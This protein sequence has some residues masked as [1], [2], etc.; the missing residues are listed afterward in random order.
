MTSCTKIGSVLV[1]ALGIFGSPA[2]SQSTATL[3]GK[4]TDSNGN[5]VY[6]ANV[7]LEGSKSGTS[8]DKEGNY[9]LTIPAG[10]ECRI[11]FSFIGFQP[12]VFE[13]SANPGQIVVY[14]AVLQ[15]SF[16]TIDEV[17]VTNA[18]DKSSNLTRINTRSLEMLPNTN[19]GI[20]TILKTLPGVSSNNEL[21]SQYSVR[22][23]NFDENLVFV[24]GI[25]VYRPFLI[26]SGQQEGLSFINPDLVGS[27]Q[28]SA[29]GFDAGYGDKMSS[30]LDVTYK[31]PAIYGGSVS[32]SLLG[33]SAHLEGSDKKHRFTHI[34][35]IR[36]KTSQYLLGT[37]DTK[38]EY[39]PR[40][41]DFQTY[42]TY[43]VS[44]TF[45]LGFLGNISRNVY[46]FI[47]VNR[48]TSFGTVSTAYKLKIYFDGQEID[49]YTGY[50]GA[51]T[52]SLHPSS[53]M[54]LRFT[55]SFYHTGEQEYFD[56]Q[57]Q[58]LINE[59]DTRIGSQTFG[60]SIK[61]IGVGTFLDHAR[62]RLNMDIWTAEHSG[63]VSLDRTQVRWG[64][65]LKQE[66]IND[67]LNE[68]QM[69]DS[70]G[71]SLPYSDS[72]INLGSVVKT[73]N[74]LS[75][76][77]FAAYLLA[78]RQADL[79]KG[80]LYASGGIRV[81]YFDLNRQFFVNPRFSI[82]FDPDWKRN[83]QFRLAAGLYFQPPLYKEMRNPAGT[84]NPNLRAQESYQLLMGSDYI[85]SLWNRPFKLT[86]EVYY[87]Y[88]DKL[89][90]Y[91]VDNVRIVYLGENMARGY[92]TGMDFKIN[93]E[94]VE[95]TESWASLSFMKTM[96]D[97]R[98]DYYVDSNG[99]KVPIG[100]YP[101]P[102]DQRVNFGMFFQDYLP[103]N[104][105]YRVNLYFL[106]GSRLPFSPPF[107]AR[108]DETYRMPAYKRVDIG[109]S[110]VIK[111]EHTSPSGTFWKPFKTI[112]VTGEIFNLFGVNNTISYLWVRTVS[113]LQN[114]PGYF[115]VPNY[116]T[117][118]RLNLRLTL[119]F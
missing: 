111:D 47:P 19:G 88:L 113:N 66:R 79:A 70:A 34:S 92:A 43:H 61:N 112:L 89:V 84:V 114:M 76:V 109:F 60:D 62:N 48:E 110:K 102:T 56:L 98:G 38:G 50:F 90:P 117:S 65:K 5:A 74:I 16:K 77:D 33:G 83:I 78:T 40:F 54:T 18:V 14:D 45:E 11:S 22:G 101:R 67:R 94:F 75:P 37:L 26:R 44:P 105:T 39:K 64:I 41:L 21:S 99:N 93:G 58:Y 46:D 55:S 2:L 42:M 119:K 1:I 103:G 116:L 63:S 8:S 7:L 91:K 82:A 72:T 106:F 3:K 59:L 49:S 118:R 96:E 15:V 57:G 17:Q 68:W 51:L 6:L 36:Y 27:V 10:Q 80:K 71:Y 52:A 12:V 31:E 108:Y 24:N 13:I 30:V 81:N 4:V 86:A 25:E 107:S 87:K 115:A 29:G 100:Y 95:G 85:F 32:G 9:S 73:H 23:G 97:I 35:G 53:R 20:E 28:F 69:L 104:P